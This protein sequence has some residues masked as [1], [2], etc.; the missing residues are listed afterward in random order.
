MRIKKVLLVDDETINH[1]ALS[2]VIEFHFGIKCESA[3]NGHDAVRLVDE[4]H[5]LGSPYKII[6]MDMNMP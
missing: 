2:S 6:F 4:A 5:R 1:F 3:F